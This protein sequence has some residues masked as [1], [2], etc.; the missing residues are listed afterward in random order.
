[1]ATERGA[2]C[3][4]ANQTIFNTEQ[5]A[6]ADALKIA[7]FTRMHEQSEILL[8]ALLSL[9]VRFTLVTNFDK[10]AKYMGY[11]VFRNNVRMACI[12]D[13]PLRA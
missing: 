5:T 13:I 7:G 1:L 3:L 9:G 6:G 8:T 12:F 2:A 10:K 11:K 4:K